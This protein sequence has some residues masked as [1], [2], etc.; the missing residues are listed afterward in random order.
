VLYLARAIAIL[1]MAVHISASCIQIFETNQRTYIVDIWTTKY[2]SILL[3]LMALLLLCAI[4]LNL[5]S[6]VCMTT[7]V[8]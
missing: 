5:Y 6:A 7:V 8:V 3:L 4:E 2:D 1:P